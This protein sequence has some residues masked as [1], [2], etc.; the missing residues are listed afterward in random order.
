[1]SIKD[2]KY[3]ERDFLIYLIFVPFR[4]YEEKKKGSNWKIKCL[5][6]VYII[7]AKNKY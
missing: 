1:M 3:S 4:K 7:Y 6:H 2:I 5:T